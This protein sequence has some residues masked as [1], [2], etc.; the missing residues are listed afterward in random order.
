MIIEADP[1]HMFNGRSYRYKLFM[2]DHID[3]T[4]RVYL[5]LASHMQQTR[6]YAVPV[7]ET[8][9]NDKHERGCWVYLDNDSDAVLLHSLLEE[10]DA[11]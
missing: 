10:K 5:K 4:K 6:A 7:V 2:S 3:R 8:G 9:Y 1:P 11:P